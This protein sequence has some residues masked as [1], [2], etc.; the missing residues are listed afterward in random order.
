MAYTLREVAVWP[1]TQR[2]VLFHPPCFRAQIDS[3]EATHWIFRITLPDG[4]DY[5]VDFANAQ[6]AGVPVR[7]HSHGIAPWDD[8]LSL[9]KSTIIQTRKPLDEA[10]IP[11]HGPYSRTKNSSQ[12]KEL[13]RIPYYFTNGERDHMTELLTQFSL[14]L[15]IKNFLIQRHLE[16]ETLSLDFLVE[17]LRYP[18]ATF[19][20]C[21]QRL[22]KYLKFFLVGWRLE[23]RYGEV[24]S[25][26]FLRRMYELVKEAM[27]GTGMQC[28][29]YPPRTTKPSG[30][31]KAADTPQQNV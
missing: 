26:D 2:L 14:I 28:P 24:A 31:A 11:E 20:F 7:I 16:D 1:R 30:D 18:K 13:L 12:A 25:G 22:L 17:I 21:A 10:F 23:L 4:S 5:A 9:T 6:F 27:I 19:T 15:S 8:Y 3:A 29:R